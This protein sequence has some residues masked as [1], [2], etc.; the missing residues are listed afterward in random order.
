MH[1][2][3]M[4]FLDNVETVPR[5]TGTYGFFGDNPQAF[6]EPIPRKLWKDKP[7]GAPIKMLNLFVTAL[8]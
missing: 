4:E 8:R 2:A 7:V 1:W 3:N 6:T 5:R